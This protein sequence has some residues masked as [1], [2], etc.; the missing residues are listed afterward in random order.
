MGLKEL[1]IIAAKEKFTL[2]EHAKQSLQLTNETQCGGSLS[3]TSMS[4]P[5]SEVDFIQWPC[6]DGID[7]KYGPI[8]IFSLILMVVVFLVFFTACFFQMD[9]DKDCQIQHEKQMEINFQVLPFLFYQRRI[10]EAEKCGVG[11][12]HIRDSQ[13]RNCFQLILLGCGFYPQGDSGL[14]YYRGELDGIDAPRSWF[15]IPKV[16]HAK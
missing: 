6:F 4:S 12:F 11:F 13:K 2:G 16:T 7:P 15:L 1:A 9:L 8:I 10:A 5:A 14:I 3:P